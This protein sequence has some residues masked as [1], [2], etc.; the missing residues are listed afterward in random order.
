M[1]SP[2]THAGAQ[3]GRS[4]SPQLDLFGGSPPAAVIEAPL[5][6][7]PRAMERP[8]SMVIRLNLDVPRVRRP[9]R[10]K[11]S[12]LPKLITADELPEYP[13]TE[14]AAVERA[15]AAIK[16]DRALLGYKE[17][18]SFFG[19]SKATINR[20]MKEGLVLGVRIKDGVVMRDGGVRRFSREQ[21]KWLLLA[22]RAGTDG[23]L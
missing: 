19:V 14:V 23:A 18:Q 22:V 9:S 11:R 6:L 10:P 3:D 17:I 1:A 20:R 21:V 7:A 13:A 15:I 8:N 12:P 16:T 4:T 2:R 5:V